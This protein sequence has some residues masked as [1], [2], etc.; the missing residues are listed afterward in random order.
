[1]LLAAPMS[2]LAGPDDEAIIRAPKRMVLLCG[3][4]NCTGYGVAASVTNYPGIATAYSAV[5]YIEQSSILVNPPTWTTDGPRDLSPR[6]ITVASH[7]A[8]T[9][10]PE[11]SMGR[12]LEENSHGEWFIAK[13]GIDTSGLENNWNNPAWPSSGGALK[14]QLTTFAAAQLASWGAELAAIVWVQGETDAGESP[15]AANYQANLAAFFGDVRTTLGVSCPII[16]NR[17]SSSYAVLQGGTVRSHQES[18]VNTDGNAGIVYADDLLFRDTV[19][20]ADDDYVTLG[21][22]LAAKVLEVIDGAAAPAHPTWKG[23]GIPVFATSAQTLTPT[24]PAHEADDIGLMVLSGIGLNTYTLST[25]AGFVAVPDSPQWNSGT[26]NNARLQVWW[27]RATSSAMA[28]P[29]IADVASDDA[30]M[31]AIVVIK[32]AATSGNPWDVTA[33]DN[34]GTASTSVTF[35]SDTTTVD[36]T[37][38]V[39]LMAYR[40]DLL[41]AQV[42]GWTNADL[43][44]LTEHFDLATA[45]G[46]GAGIAI[47]TGV[48]ATAGAF[49]G[50]TA[51]LATSA[52]QARLTI[53]IK[54]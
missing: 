6:T 10:G 9:F 22:R 48:K 29:T 28:A 19:H 23:A 4:S 38:I 46:G 33:G 40:L 54:P 45:T 18:F 32:G 30:K 13:M 37:L 51:T 43:T 52:T 25:A 50:T 27:C 49:A 39:N 1:V 21:L 17:M 34:I 14:T 53:A 41:G 47:A 44:E 20:F 24:W 15:D 31:A 12:Y 11:L 7:V 5:Q 35:P 36:N 26:N 2:T 3:Q 42:S 16:L 8:G